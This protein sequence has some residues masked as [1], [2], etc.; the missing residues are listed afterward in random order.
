VKLLLIT[1]E[2]PPSGGVSVQR[3]L[4]FAKYLPDHGFEVHVL[5]ARNPAS[6]VLDPGLLDQVPS[7]VRVHRAWTPEPSYA[8][9]KRLWS[10][11]SS[12]PSG[13][14]PASAAPASARP[15]ENG[16]GSV[17]HR[18]KRIAG[19][20]VKWMLAPDPH[21]LWLPFAYRRACQIIKRYGIDVVVTTVPPFSLL[22]LANRLKRRFPHLFM[23]SDFRDEWRR[24]FLADFEFLNN[25]RTRRLAERIER[26]AVERSSLVLAATR[27]SLEQIRQN[28]ADTV[29]FAWIPNGFDPTAFRHFT[30]RSH[31]GTG[32][33]VTYIGTTYK[34][35]SPRFYLDAL[36][37]LP[38]SI[39]SRFET[40]L[41]GRVIEEERQVLEGRRSDVR[42]FGFLPQSEAF[43]WM[44]ETDYLLVT[45]T[46]DF[47]VAGKLFE[48]LATGKPILAISP[49][50]G[51]V[52]RLIEETGGGWCVD[53]HD[54]E[55][56]KRMLT[57]V[58]QHEGESATLQPNRAA[59]LQYERP[60]LAAALAERIRRVA[61]AR[62]PDPSHASTACS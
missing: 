39:R 12:R 44:E 13:S 58:C 40:R 29:K 21:V 62:R 33:V 32:I 26:E 3:A 50:H 55:G 42:V 4:G 48:Y 6:P 47:A 25:P 27:T 61:L 53:P 8:L 28:D 24:Y 51:E 56:I 11:T 45:V 34:V 41:I 35:C 38:E 18:V 2:F 54:H 43:R 31:P 1:Y 22:L 60:R 9:R 16:T 57:M 19:E 37:D 59:I 49:M 52:A 23:V 30:P 36:D 10:L 46:N 15:A 14:E 5:T 7:H 17:V 20:T